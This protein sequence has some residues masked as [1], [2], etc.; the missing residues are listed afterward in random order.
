MKLER[1][2][3]ALEDEERIQHA[4]GESAAAKTVERVQQ[5]QQALA[6]AHATSGALVTQP[7]AFAMR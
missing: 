7:V 3:A 2:P 5:Q 4:R 1:T 6:G